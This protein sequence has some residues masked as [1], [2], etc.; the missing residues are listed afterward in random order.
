[1]MTDAAEQSNMSSGATM[2]R[3]IE[4]PPTPWWRTRTVLIALAIAGLAALAWGLI[5]ASGSTDVDAANIQTAAIART[6]FDDFLAVRAKVVPALTTFVGVMTAGQVERVLV[7]DGAL[8]RDHMPLA[9]LANPELRLQVLSQE[10]QITGQLGNVAGENLGIARSRIDRQVQVSQAEYDLIR[11]QRDLSV[12][13]QLHDRGFVSDAGVRSYAQEVAYQEKRL[14]Q[15]QTG[16]AAEARITAAQADL[17]NTARAR[18]QSN[19]AAVRAGLS[20][21]VIR[22]SAAG[23]LTNFALQPGQT[24]K[25]GDPAGQIDSEGSWKLEADVDEYYLGRIAVGQPAATSGGAA[26]TVSRILPTV[27]D[28]RF[29]VELR[30]DSAPRQS[31]NR[32]QTLDVRVTLGAA[33]PAITAPVGGWLTQGGDHVFVLNEAGNRAT[34]RAVRIGRR[35]PRRVEVLSGLQPG[36]RI[37]TSDLSQIS[38]DSINIR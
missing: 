22:A 30:F 33:V 6:S 15:L 10:A 35:N 37:V 36:D 1:M 28:G 2:D 17:L 25:P 3:R 19:Q 32:G 12:R 5:P 11:A 27:T 16:S 31:F 20:A 23:R 38:G 34:R 4:R 21:L 14:A 13:Q 29:R 8:V 24:V 26:L 9:T 7:Q 18:L